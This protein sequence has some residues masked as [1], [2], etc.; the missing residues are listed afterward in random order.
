MSKY[1]LD[2]IHI[3]EIEAMLEQLEITADGLYF[4]LLGE[5]LELERHER[6]ARP[7]QATGLIL[8]DLNDIALD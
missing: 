3:S 8:D 4:R 7:A 5:V 6:P 2:N 1:T